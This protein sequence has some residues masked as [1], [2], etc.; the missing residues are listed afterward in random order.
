MFKQMFHLS[1]P[2]CAT[3]LISQTQKVVHCE[4]HLWQWHTSRHCRCRHKVTTATNS[5]FV[6]VFVAFPLSHPQKLTHLLL[7]LITH[8]LLLIT[9]FIFYSVLCTLNSAL[10]FHSVLST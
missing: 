9:V 7:S 10:S 5:P 3:L 2:I 6:V 8:H 4:Q 1:P